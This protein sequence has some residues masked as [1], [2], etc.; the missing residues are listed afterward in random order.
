MRLRRVVPL[1]AVAAVVL[2]LVGRAAVSAR[3]DRDLL[4]RELGRQL[5]QPVTLRDYTLA[6]DGHVRID[7][8]TVGNVLKVRR[9]ET[10]LPW[11]EVVRGEIRPRR[12]TLTEP[13]LILQ[14]DG[15]ATP[16]PFP[17]AFQNATLRWGDR[18]PVHPVNGEWDGD[19]WEASHPQAG[20]WRKSQHQ[21]RVENLSLRWWSEWLGRPLPL[22]DPDRASALVNL[23][24]PW[25]AELEL[26]YGHVTVTPSKASA[27]LVR[28]EDKTL[29][30]VELLYDLTRREVTRASAVTLW[31]KVT[32]EGHLSEEAADAHVTFPGGEG[33]LKGPWSDPRLTARATVGGLPL[34]GTLTRR[35]GRVTGPRGLDVRLAEGKIRGTLRTGVP[36]EGQWKGA[37]VHVEAR[38]LPVL[39]GKADATLDADVL[40]QTATVKGQLQKWQVQGLAGPPATF[41]AALANGTWRPVALE[42]AGVKPPVAVNGTLRPL[43][44]DLTLAGQNVTGTKAFGTVH[45]EGSA[46]QAKLELKPLKYQGMSVALARVDVQGPPW[47][48]TIDVPALQLPGVNGTVAVEARLPDQLTFSAPELTWQG[49]KFPLAG[50][51]NGTLVKVTR[52]WPLQG[53]YLPKLQKVALTGKLKAV[54]LTEFAPSVAGNLTG[55]VA[56]K[57]GL[58]GASGTFQGQVAKL[59]VADLTGPTAI[60]KARFTLGL[61]I[62]LAVSLPKPRW[63]ERALPPLQTQLLV[64]SANTTIRELTMAGQVARGQFTH[65]PPVLTLNSSLKAAPLALLPFPVSGTATGNLSVKGQS[66]RFAGTM[67]ELEGWG[68]R[69]GN[70]QLSVNATQPPLTFTAQGKGFQPERLSFLNDRFPGLHGTLRFAAT[71][72][73]AE[74]H[75]EGMSQGKEFLPGVSVWLTPAGAVRRLL[76]LTTPPLEL[77]GTLKPLELKGQLTGQSLSDLLRLSGGRPNPDIGMR[78][79]GPVT[80]AQDQLTFQGTVQELT[81][82][83]A[84]LGSGRLTLSTAPALD[85][86][87]VLDR[88]LSVGEV[89]AV[90]LAPPALR[91]PVAQILGGTFLQHVRVTGVRLQGSLDSPRL[92]P[93]FS[94]L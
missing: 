9:A 36:L 90:G 55:T 57:A 81:Y 42:F 89:A 72:K 59:H 19:R 64:G 73:E 18:P 29:R 17:V 24:T 3:L 87:L 40:R 91:S 27:P 7:D 13:E 62:A 30:D 94:G 61:P 48:G 28:F 25:Q 20:T 39:E 86:R 22:P 34:K 26:P 63:G 93:E 84:Q 58:K 21:L 47:R 75:L 33:T 2:W 44:L 70:G 1:L 5:G 11:G 52:P 45:L 38:Q 46:I 15:T 77:A 8:L 23:D 71:E 76:V 83:R 10:V 80:L 79:T 49:R 82:R 78:L 60:V 16:P 85:G 69:L 56:V 54:S 66:V 4:A 32:L 35:E 74:V 41:E 53:R 43:K 67:A 12:L 6:L 31:G 51:V 92:T 88:P 37:A 65:D 14:G 68:Y 50:S